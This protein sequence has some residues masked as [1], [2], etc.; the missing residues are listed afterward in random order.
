MQV[1]KWTKLSPPL[2]I[3]ACNTSAEITTALWIDVTRCYRCKWTDS[4]TYA[5]QR[6]SLVSNANRSELSCASWSVGYSL[7]AKALHSHS[8]QVTF[9]T[10]GSYFRPL[11]KCPNQVWD[12]DL[13]Q[14][15]ESETKR[16][17]VTESFYS[18]EHRIRTDCMWKMDI[19]ALMSPTD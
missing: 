18:G 12:G 4:S 15:S 9:F 14:T 17:Q 8:A 1:N 7:K 2:T 11:K 10:K 5:T 19:A 3:S 13:H 16:K 6:S